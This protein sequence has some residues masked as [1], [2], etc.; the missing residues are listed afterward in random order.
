MQQFLWVSA[1]D[2]LLCRCN[3]PAFQL[4][5]P[6]LC[7]VWLQNLALIV[8]GIGALFSLV[9]HLGTTESKREAGGEAGG[10]EGKRRV[11]EEEQEGERKPLLPRPE[12]LS[13]LLQWKCWLQQP[14]FYQVGSAPGSDSDIGVTWRS[15]ASSC[16]GRLRQK[17]FNTLTVATSCVL[18][19][20][21]L[22]LVCATLYLCRWPYSTCPPG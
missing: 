21:W 16:S 10:E 7:H 6:A 18:S 3:I 19:H 5:W 22:T 1:T 17:C 4:A 8:L 14:S 12:T 13:S 20:P 2:I 15:S 9:F 11:E